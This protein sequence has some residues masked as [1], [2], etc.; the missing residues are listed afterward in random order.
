MFKNLVIAAAVMLTLTSTMFAGTATAQ[1]LDIVDTAISAGSF[2][3]LV[4]AV[5]AAEL[6]DTLKS[7]GPWT[8]FA[9]TDE[10]FA[11]LPSGTVES[12]LE[13]GNRSKLLAV[14]KYHVV[15]GEVMSSDVVNI[16]SAETVMGQSLSISTS[17]SSVMIDNAKVVAADVDASNGVIHV[18]DS[19]LLP[20]DIVTVASSAGS[21]N[22]LVAAVQAAGL[23]D[24]LRSGGPFTVFAPTDEAFAKLPAGTID[25]LL[26]PENKDQLISILTY[27]VVPGSVYASDVVSLDSAGTV[28]GAPVWIKASDNG[29]WVNDA[30]VIATDIPAFNGVIHVIDTVILPGEGSAKSKADHSA[31]TRSNWAGGCG[32]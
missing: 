29:V 14:L 17:G 22:T 25:E 7:E 28:N 15:S 31:T 10:A 2:E 9:P 18:I 5:S 24:T 20:A 6:A 21:F 4:A 19:V 27:H 1:Q 13:P 32:H 26:K 11:K 16:D 12:L 23:E 8:V 30:S 3:T